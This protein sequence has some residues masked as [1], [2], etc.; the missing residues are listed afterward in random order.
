MRDTPWIKIWMMQLCSA[1]FHIFFQIFYIYIHKKYICTDSVLFLGRI[2]KIKTFNFRG[3]L[4]Q[5]WEYIKNLLVQFCCVLLHTYFCKNWSSYL[6]VD[7]IATH[8]GCNWKCWIIKKPLNSV[9]FAY[10]LHF[11]AR[12]GVCSSNGFRKTSLDMKDLR[13]DRRA[14]MGKSISLANWSIALIKS[15]YTS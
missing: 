13:T 7:S 6:E 11:C 10:R 4:W 1:R 5:K 15:T 2:F 9:L 8:L 12:Y 3:V 14:D